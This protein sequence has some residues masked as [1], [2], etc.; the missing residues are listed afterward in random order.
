MTGDSTS[1]E[2]LK[3]RI[4]LLERKCERYHDEV[5]GY[6]DLINTLKSRLG[7]ALGVEEGLRAMEL[8]DRAVLA[9]KERGNGD[10]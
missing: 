1:K 5:E 9:L 10:D 4:R 7:E 6:M 3:T 8:V 2:V